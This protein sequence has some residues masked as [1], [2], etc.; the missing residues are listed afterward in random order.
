MPLD[1]ARVNKTHKLSSINV[2]SKGMIYFT[3]RFTSGCHSIAQRLSAVKRKKNFFVVVF[4][5][6]AQD[7]HGEELVV[8]SK[9]PVI[10]FFLFGENCFTFL[11]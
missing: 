7:S 3:N 2:I 8:T 4:L 1:H 11:E 9:L 5:L 6:S 10:F